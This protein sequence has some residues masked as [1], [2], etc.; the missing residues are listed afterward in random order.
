MFTERGSN[1]AVLYTSGK[2]IDH[3]ISNGDSLTLRSTDQ[4]VLVRDVIALEP[5]RY[6][7]TIYGFEPSRALE[8]NG[9]LMDQQVEFREPHV[10]AVRKV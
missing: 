1:D 2:I 8:H 10:F 5:G 7:G 4:Y 3:T 6:K 9:L